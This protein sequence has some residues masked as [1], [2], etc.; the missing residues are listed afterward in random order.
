MPIFSSA[1]VAWALGSLHSYLTRTNDPTLTKEAIHAV[2]PMRRVAFR[3]AVH[4]QSR[5]RVVYTAA[6]MLLCWGS[7]DLFPSD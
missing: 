7:S 3:L 6:R 1:S 4:T 5:I 2:C